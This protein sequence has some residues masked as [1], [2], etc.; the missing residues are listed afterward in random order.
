[1]HLS[2][3]EYMRPPDV[4]LKE[5]T[6]MLLRPQICVKYTNRPTSKC[7]HRGRLIIR[8]TSK[9]GAIQLP[10]SKAKCTKFDF[11]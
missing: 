2:V 6:R 5:G 7:A 11:H 9:I 10:D 1:V 3:C 8:K 4:L